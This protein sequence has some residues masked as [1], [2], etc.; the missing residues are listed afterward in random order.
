MMRIDA[1]QHF[2]TLDGPFTHAWLEAGE[3][4]RIRKN[5]LPSDLANHVA[6]HRLDGTVF[7]QTQ[8]DPREHDWVLTLA[9][10]HAWIKGVVGWVDL[11]APDIAA[12]LAA[13]RQHPKFVGIRHAIPSDP[14]GGWSIPPGIRRGLK[15]LET[16]GLVF[17]LLIRSR[18][19]P[20]VPKLADDFP[21]LKFV[22]DHCAKPDVRS[23]TTAGWLDALRA[24]G[25]RPNV[26]CKLSGLVTEADHA[27]WTPD[28][29][30]PFAKAALQAF[31][32]RRLMWGSDWPVCLLAS[33]YGRWLATAEALVAD[34]SASDRDWIFGGTATECYG[35]KP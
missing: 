14:D 29:L 31:G 35:L 15:A 20:F 26:W 12:R 22:I 23:G 19:L 28:H 9:D 6:A 3:H 16:A 32:P 33:E 18:D 11:A 21:K 10:A 4:A 7:V 25:R 5:F 17:D 1:H 30:A 8:P 24:C 13:A 34:D 27:D 2:W